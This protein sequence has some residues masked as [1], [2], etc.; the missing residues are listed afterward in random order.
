MF[1]GSLLAA[2]TWRGTLQ[3]HPM[4]TSSIA[5]DLPTTCARCYDPTDRVF[6]PFV[7]L[8]LLVADG[9]RGRG[10]GQAR[11]HDRFAQGDGVAFFLIAL[12]S[13]A[14]STMAVVMDVAIRDG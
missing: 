6:H 4:S 10:C 1:T 5:H 3:M 8:R 11:V 14:E 7:F 2:R 12:F 13:R 9:D